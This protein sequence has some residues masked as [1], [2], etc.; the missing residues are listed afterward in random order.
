MRKTMNKFREKNYLL[1]LTFFL[2]LTISK[3]TISQGKLAEIYSKFA[4]IESV[5]ANF[6]ETKKSKVF[7]TEQIQKGTVFSSRN[8]KLIWHVAE[9]VE[10]MF[11]IDG[12]TVK[13]SYPDLNYEKYYDLRNAGVISEVAKNIFAIVSISGY[14]I[15]EKNYESTIKGNWKN[16]WQ[17]T[18]IPKQKEVKKAITKMTLN[19]T[20]NDFIT[21]I[22]IFEGNGDITKIVFQNIKLNPASK[23]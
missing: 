13:I 18:L 3:K 2:I 21:S 23:K 4:N 19:I 5:E 8:G 6:T 15:I 11:I 7:Q 17:I 14:K 12:N 1:Y 9:P 22:E 16:G 10:N 20:E